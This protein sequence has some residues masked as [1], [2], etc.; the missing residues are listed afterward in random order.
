MELS[1]RAN[2][3]QMSMILCTQW[4]RWQSMNYRNYS[5]TCAPL[6]CNGP[7]CR[8]QT[9]KKFQI[10]NCIEWEKLIMN[11]TKEQRRKKWIR[12]GF[13]L[14]SHLCLR[15]GLVMQQRVLCHAPDDDD[16]NCSSFSAAK[17]AFMVAIRSFS[18]TYRCEHGEAARNCSA[19]NK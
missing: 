4:W 2:V 16:F 8:L 13:C 10:A 17:T 11:S 18:G 1:N 3:D 14:R 7:V 9:R 12:F 15:L 19:N 6:Q 5:K